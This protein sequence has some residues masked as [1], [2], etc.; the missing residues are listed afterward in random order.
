[1]VILNFTVPFALEAIPK[2]LKKRT[3][4][5]VRENPNS[6]WNRLWVKWN[7]KSDLRKEYPTLDKWDG[8][9]LE[10]FDKHSEKILVKDPIQLQLWW[11][12]RSPFWICKDCGKKRKFNQTERDL[13]TETFKHL[14]TPELMKPIACKHCNGLTYDKEAHKL[15]DAVLVNMTKRTLGTLKEYEWEADG[16]E[17]RVDGCVIPN[18]MDSATNEG[19]KWFMETYKITR[20]DAENLAVY[21][22]EWELV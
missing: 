20:E 13:Y 17:K 4:R 19:F 7:I 12:Q 9:E 15:A 1:M 18:I 16:F 10:F 11:Q 3:M 22:I 8:R 21:I 14:L 6:V 2:G 5:P